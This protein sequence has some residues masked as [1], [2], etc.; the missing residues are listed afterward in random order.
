MRGQCP[1]YPARRWKHDCKDDSSTEIHG[2]IRLRVPK[3]PMASSTIAPMI[4]KI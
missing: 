4:D 1:D 2:M 3:N